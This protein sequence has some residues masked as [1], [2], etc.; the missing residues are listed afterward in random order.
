MDKR[1]ALKILMIGLTLLFVAA[2]GYER[3]RKY[4]QAER[5]RAIFHS[6][7]SKN[8][9]RGRKKTAESKSGSAAASPGVKYRYSPF[10]LLLAFI[11]VVVIV[12]I[13]TFGLLLGRAG[14]IDAIMTGNLTGL[15]RLLLL[16]V[17]AVCLSFLFLL[18]TTRHTYC[19]VVPE[20]FLFRRKG[21]YVDDASVFMP[22]ESITWI[23]EWNRELDYNLKQA[24]IP[25][26]HFVPLPY[27]PFLLPKWLLLYSDGKYQFALIFYPPPQMVPILQRE[28]CR[29]IN[30]TKNPSI[31]PNM[32]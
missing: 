16:V 32:S 12:G 9:Y 11:P 29:S 30:K 8:E 31:L 5:R 24:R 22:T 17:L 1:F 7:N 6:R 25:L 18:S 23:G 3:K 26:T 20:G 4:G 10:R 28:Y 15:Q 13:T 14:S 2:V 27:F 19:E 21:S